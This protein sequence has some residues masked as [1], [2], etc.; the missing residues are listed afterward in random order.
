V[1]DLLAM[2]RISET[3]VSP[4]GKW[5]VFTLRKTDLEANRGRTDLWLVGVDGAGLRQLTS[6]PGS[7]FSPAWSRDGKS[8]WFLSTRSGSAQVWRIASD[9]GEAE[10]KTNLPFDVGTFQLSPDNALLAVTMEVFP[11]CESIDC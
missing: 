7:D 5:A 1:H 3:Q 10:Q 11:E 6:H 2:D 4:E 9:G 8:I